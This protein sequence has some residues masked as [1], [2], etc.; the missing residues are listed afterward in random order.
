MEKITTKHF[1]LSKNQYFGILLRKYFKR[2]IW[3]YLFLW[4]V[5]FFI[6][7]ID[8]NIVTVILILYAVLYPIFICLFIYIKAL[9]AK[10]I[11][12]TERNIELSNKT[13]KVN[14]TNHST[15]EFNIEEFIEIR[16]YKNFCMAYLSKNQYIYIPKKAFENEKKFQRFIRNLSRK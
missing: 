14:I 5:T 16:V 7:L 9:K 12:F 2:R 6:T 8:I 11:I 15:S 4:I 13:L 1:Q 3:F 10:D